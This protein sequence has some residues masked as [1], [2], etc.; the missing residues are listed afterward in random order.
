MTEAQMT[1]I[2]TAL[3]GLIDQAVPVIIAVA[4]AGLALWGIPKLISWVKRGLGR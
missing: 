1:E 3:T 4:I 2:E